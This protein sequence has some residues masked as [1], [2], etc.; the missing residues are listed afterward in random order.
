MCLCGSSDLGG[1]L[2]RSSFGVAGRSLICSK[3]RCLP[4]RPAGAL[5]VQ[6]FSYYTCLLC[7]CFT[8][9]GVV[10]RG[11]SGTSSTGEPRSRSNRLWCLT[12]KCRLYVFSDIMIHK[13]L[14]LSGRPQVLE[15]LFA[16]NL[17]LIR[18]SSMFV[19]LC[20]VCLQVSGPVFFCRSVSE[21][22]LQTH[23]TPPL[24]GCTYLGLDSGAPPLQVP[25]TH[26]SPGRHAC[27]ITMK[28]FKTS[29]L[30]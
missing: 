26:H 16:V 9:D 20:D 27:H 13:N 14:N 3:S 12:G 15:Q 1:F 6:W 4:D 21:K 10:Y 30:I 29:L 19:F 18:S 23:V 7:C 11:G 28:L 25:L 2:W 17:F 22:L 24:D 8:H 5:L